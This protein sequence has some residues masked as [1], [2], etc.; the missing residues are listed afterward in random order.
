MGL[1]GGADGDH[2]FGVARPDD[3]DEVGAEP[4]QPQMGLD[5]GQYEQVVRL[6]GLDDGLDAIVGPEDVT[7]A[8]DHPHLGSPGG[9]VEVGLR[10]DLGHGLRVMAVR[11]PA[12]R[13]RRRLGDVEPALERHHQN[14]PA[15]D[16]LVTPYDGHR[17]L[18]SH[19]ERPG[20][21]TGRSAADPGAA[22]LGKKDPGSAWREGDLVAGSV[23]EE[24]YVEGRVSPPHAGDEL[25]PG[26]HP[27]ISRP[28]DAHLGAV[29]VRRADP[30]AD[31]LDDQVRS[32]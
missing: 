27:G 25:A 17:F 6:V 30:V 32:P 28:G 23:D 7:L 22:R 31:E 5:A 2:Q 10:V 4:P 19:A 11:Q 3:L 16:D 18:A 20:A 13:A 29:G 15:Q 14:R 12:Q 9:E 8:A 1:W 26:E 21:V 24:G